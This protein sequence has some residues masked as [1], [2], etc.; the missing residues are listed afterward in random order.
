ML[1][2][3][4]NFIVGLV[5]CVTSVLG[6]LAYVARPVTVSGDSMEP[7]LKDGNLL[8]VNELNKTI[9]NPSRFDIVI[10]DHPEKGYLVKRLIG[11]PGEHI[12]YSNNELFINGEKIDE[13]F[14]DNYITYSGGTPDMTIHTADYEITLKD[15]EYLILGDNR[16]VSFDSRTFGPVKKDRIMSYGIW[17]KI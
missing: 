11:L 13:D 3:L 6:V 16:E 8:I 9:D 14:Y 12:V 17:W 7:C 4:L 2:S 15:D 1:K 10:Y 5:M